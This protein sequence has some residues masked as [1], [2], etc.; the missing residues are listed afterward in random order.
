M[1]HTFLCWL[2]R[3][4]WVNDGVMKYES[5][6]ADGQSERLVQRCDHCFRVRF[7]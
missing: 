4:V 3:H 7:L 6:A 5:K 1:M 2:G